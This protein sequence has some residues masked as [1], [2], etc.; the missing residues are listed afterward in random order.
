MNVAQA[1][2]RLDVGIVRLYGERV[3]EEESCGAFALCYV[4]A[5]FLIAAEWAAQ[6]QKVRSDAAPEAGGAGP[7]RPGKTGRPGR[8]G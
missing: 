8:P 1:L 7:G 3:N 4:R 2:E 5:N 6:T